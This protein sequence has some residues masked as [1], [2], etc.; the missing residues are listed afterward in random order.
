MTHLFPET[1]L[2]KLQESGFII[3]LWKTFTQPVVSE[4]F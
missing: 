1:N 4:D 2:Q 3:I